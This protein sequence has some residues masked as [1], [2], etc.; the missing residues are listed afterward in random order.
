MFRIASS[1]S[2]LLQMIAVGSACGLLAVAGAA[3]QPK[4]A[5]DPIPAIA[6]ATEEVVRVPVAAHVRQAPPPPAPSRQLLFV[7]AAGDATYVKLAVDDVPEHGPHRLVENEGI[8][9]TVAEVDAAM[10]PA[11]F[12][13]W[14]GKELV[15]DGACRAKVTGFS[16][17]TRLIGDPGYAGIEHTESWT[18]DTVAEKGTVSFAAR[19]DDCPGGTYARDA[20]LAPIA[21]FEQIEDARL[22]DTARSA[23]LASDAAKA[24]ELAWREERSRDAE[25]GLATAGI[26]GS[27]LDHVSVTSRVVRHP[28]TGVT[29][30]AIHAGGDRSCGGPDINVWGLFRVGAKGELRTVHVKQLETLYSVDRIIDIDDDG[31]P[32][33]IGNDWLG[34]S[35]IL[36]TAD[37]T[38]VSRLAMRFYGCPC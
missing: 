20:E 18:A 29:W 8:V 19:I 30:V 9:A 16:V 25:A 37:G 5:S 2:H 15:V 33:L 6:T 17:V 24:A 7:F 13:S 38:E 11:R 22:L 26:A 36:T 14:L 35:R 28:R 10:V 21:T 31:T 1:S 34:M 27:W 12:K 3:T 23:F 4:V 32:E